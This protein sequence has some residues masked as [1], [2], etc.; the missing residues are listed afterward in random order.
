[1]FKHRKKLILSISTLI[2]GQ[3]CF[4]RSWNKYSSQKIFFYSFYCGKHRFLLWLMN[5]GTSKKSR[6]N[7]KGFLPFYHIAPAEANLFKSC[8]LWQNKGAQYVSL[9][10]TCLLLCGPACYPLFSSLERPAPNWFGLGI[11]SFANN[12]FKFFSHDLRR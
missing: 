7:S 9:L 10:L 4:L 2:M 6:Y 8:G 3:L 5:Y 1:M 11:L 12:V